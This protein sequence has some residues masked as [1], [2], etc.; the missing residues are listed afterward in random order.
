MDLAGRSGIYT[1][2]MRSYRK[3]YLLP[4]PPMAPSEVTPS[5]SGKIRMLQPPSRVQGRVN[6]G[7]VSES[8]IDSTA[9]KIRSGQAGCSKDCQ[10]YLLYLCIFSFISVL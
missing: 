1:E 7:K 5:D 3:L 4:S 8:E 9:A 6:Y 2:L 10:L